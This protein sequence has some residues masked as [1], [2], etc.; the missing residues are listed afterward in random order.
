MP[1]RRQAR[2]AGPRKPA[3]GRE[4]VHDLVYR[5]LRRS[6]MVGTFAPGEK[7]SLRSLARQ[8]GTSLTPVR[9]AVNRLTAEGAFKVLP[10]RW[11]VIPPMSREKFDEITEWR[12]AL[13]TEATRKACERLTAAKLAAIRKLN[14]RIGRHM[15]ESGD[16]KDLLSI[17]YDFHFSIYRAGGS[18]LLLSM[19]ESLWLQ[20]GPFTYYS[21]LSPRELWSA[22]HHDAII[23]ALAGRDAD[24]AAAAVRRDILT[25]AAFLREHGHYGPPRLNRVTA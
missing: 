14:R 1:E 3:A 5:E 7:V 19:I 22:S 17:N 2:R 12:V 16:R 4:T 15:A 9:A 13:E 18:R 25:A 11:V 10:N 24:A 8:L 6:L 20:E 21:L 23:E